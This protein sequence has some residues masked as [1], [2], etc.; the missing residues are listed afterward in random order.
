MSPNEAP[1]PDGFDPTEAKI[2]ALLRD[3][4]RAE[5]PVTLPP[6]PAEAPDDWTSLYPAEA[7]SVSKSWKWDFAAPALLAS[8]AVLLACGLWFLPRRE[9]GAQL[10]GKLP[11]EA[12]TEPTTPAVWTPDIVGLPPAPT[13]VKSRSQ[14]QKVKDG[15]VAVTVTD[16]DALVDL[17]YYSTSLGTVE[18]RTNV[19][20]TTVRVWEPK[21]GE[22]LQATVPSIRV[23]V[24][25]LEQ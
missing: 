22:W 21:S 2:D 17:K 23:E 7:Q 10:A 13:S 3:F 1:S 11:P 18:Q 16:G 19:E 14:W 6:T 12:S 15:E 9:N 20:W 24:V 5:T 25:P 8:L 4:F